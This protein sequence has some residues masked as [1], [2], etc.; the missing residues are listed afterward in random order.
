MKTINTL[1]LLLFTSF[2][3]AQNQTINGDL[4]VKGGTTD[5][6]TLNERSIIRKANSWSYSDHYLLRSGWTSSLADYLYLGSAGNNVHTL[7]AAM[8]LSEA[9]GL[10]FGKGTED[11]NSIS[12]TL[13]SVHPFGDMKLYSNGSNTNGSSIY[14]R[15]SN[16]NADDVISTIFF[17]NNVGSAARI[18]AETSGASNNGVF[19]IQT[20]NA[21]VLAD[22]LR[23][24]QNG[25]TTING[26]IYQTGQVRFNTM[27]NYVR[28]NADNDAPLRVHSN[29]GWAGIGFNDGQGESFIYYQGNQDQYQISSGVKIIGNS[30]IQGDLES[31][32]VKVTAASGSVPDYV[33]AEDYELRT[34]NELERYVEANRHLPNIPSAKQI[35]KDGQNVGD[36]Q[37]KL[38]EKIEELVLYTIQQQKEIED[39]KTQ[40]SKAKKE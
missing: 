39:L 21:G 36:L 32:K 37:L 4:I 1:A 25:S 38:L 9:Q 19:K 15:H 11:G 26:D 27:S 20:A 29:D 7:N 3:Y 23:I 16:N 28:I 18:I 33:F 14:L 13:F 31:R 2:V 5:N 10:T 8:V 35:E 22:R 12:S 30:V 40:L 34:L 17:Q 24:D 6:L